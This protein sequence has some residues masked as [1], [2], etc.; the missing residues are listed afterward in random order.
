MNCPVCDRSLAPTLSICTACGAM[1]HDTV[2]EVI[3]AKI[4]PGTALRVESQTPPAPIRK[5][6]AP[7]PA[8]AAPTMSKRNET[9]GLVP[10]KTSPTLVEFQN[11]DASLPDW[12]LQLQNAVQQRRCGQ[13][14]AAAAPA[15]ERSFPTIGG[16]A[17]KADIVPAAAPA[18]AVKSLDPRVAKAL[19]RIDRSREIFLHTDE[20]KKKMPAGRP[21]Q[22]RSF[23]FDVVSPNNRPAISFGVH[24][25]VAAPSKPKLVVPPPSVEKKDTNKLPPLKQYF[26]RVIPFEEMV[27]EKL[28]SEPPPEFSEINRIRI[29]ADAGGEGVEQTLV[30]TD[31]IEDLATFSMRFGAGLFDMIIGAFTSLLILAPL[32]FNGANWAT[33][34]GGLIFVAAWAIISFVYLTASLGFFGK[35]LGMRLFSLELVDAVENEYPTLHQAAVS[36]SIFLLSLAFLGV[37]FMTALFNEE[38]RALHDLLSGTILVREF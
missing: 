20:P 27:A 38:R 5:S 21:A 3:Q 31:E 15:S 32:A 19:S 2:R 37:G 12:R 29:S 28:N 34:S 10:S 16:L 36:S 17:V 8:S 6:L 4:M 9:A 18:V 13:N 30:E 11:K 14:S 1:M 23:P 33:G 22:M 7:R 25:P 24:P 26:E 35:T